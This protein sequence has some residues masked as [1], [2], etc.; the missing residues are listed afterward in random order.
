MN[1]LNFLILYPLFMSVF[2]IVGTIIYMF[3]SELWL[4]QK[5]TKAI[6]EEGISFLV[7]C[8]N[9]EE[10]IKDTIE[11]LLSLEF[12]NKSLSSMMEVQII[13]HRLFISFKKQWISHL[14]ILKSIKGK[15]ML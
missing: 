1:L 14:S 12:P 11:N 10:T 3:F 9:E 15:P 8:F 4:T 2:W 13:L 7:P 5:P 6:G